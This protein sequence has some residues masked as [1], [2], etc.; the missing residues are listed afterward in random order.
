VEQPKGPAVATVPAHDCEG[1]VRN[2]SS[3]WGGPNMSIVF[4]FVVA[5]GVFFALG[6]AAFGGDLRGVE[7]RLE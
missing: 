1:S 4:K 6:R 2:L 3:N 5:A 7:H